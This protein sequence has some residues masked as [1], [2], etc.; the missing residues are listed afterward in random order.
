MNKLATNQLVLKSRILQIEAA[1]RE[2][3]LT[4]TGMYLL[5]NLHTTFIQL[6]EVLDTI[7]RIIEELETA[8]TFAKIAVLHP[9][10]IEPE[11]LLQELQYISEYL[12]DAILPYS[13]DREH[14]IIFEKI[15]NIKAY[16]TNT[17]I[18]FILEVPIV[19]PEY[20]NYYHL[21]SF[22][23]HAEQDSYQIIIPETEFLYLNEHH[24]IFSN[25]P[26]Q[27]VIPGEAMCALPEANPIDQRTPCE[28]NL[29]LFTKKYENCRPQHIKLRDKKI[30]KINSN[31]WLGIFPNETTVK[32]ICHKEDQ[33]LISK[34]RHEVLCI[35]P[36]CIQIAATTKPDAWRY[37]RLPWNLAKMQDR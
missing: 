26:C 9:F 29:I 35:K 3:D 5:I 34:Q 10:I 1:V 30:Q 23:V 31:Q 16:Q 4:K 22:P 11:D 28:V 18:V 6:I 14:I 37:S 21:Y 24:Y 2:Q 17:K 25:E 32:S 27:E 19:E 36:P 15:I 8:I 20:Y 7:L 12:D 33:A 13:P